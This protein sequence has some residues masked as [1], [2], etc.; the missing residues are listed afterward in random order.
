MSDD[1]ISVS[2]VYD[3]VAAAFGLK[4]GGMSEIDVS[5]ATVS[6]LNSEGGWTSIGTGSGVLNIEVDCETTQ[7]KLIPSIV[8]QTFTLTFDSDKMYQKRALNRL[9]GAL[10]LWHRRN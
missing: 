2:E 8:N 10:L 6:Y 3:N 4:G 7:R 1:R 9:W 5:N